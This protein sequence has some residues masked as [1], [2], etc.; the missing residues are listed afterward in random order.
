MDRAPPGLD[1]HELA[2]SLRQLE[3]VSDVHHLH[4][5]ELD[6][7]HRAMEAHVRTNLPPEEQASLRTRIKQRAGKRYEIHHSTI[8]IEDD[9]T[10][11]PCP[12]KEL[13]PPH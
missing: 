10:E 3:G 8:E 11:D 13:F 6:E 1:L 9:T 7:H 2:E 4:V 12:E 5:R